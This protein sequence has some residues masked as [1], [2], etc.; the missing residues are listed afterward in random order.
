MVFISSIVRVAGTTAR[1]AVVFVTST[2]TGAASIARLCPFLSSICI[3][4]FKVAACGKRL[5]VRGR[6]L[7]FQFR[8]GSAFPCKFGHASLCVS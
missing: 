6:Q 2:L 1:L 7:Y 3:A 8:R 4:N 5:Q